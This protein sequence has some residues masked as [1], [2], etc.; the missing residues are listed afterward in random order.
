MHFKTNWTAVIGKKKQ[1]NS[2]PGNFLSMAAFIAQEAVV[3]RDRLKGFFDL[4]S[5][6]CLLL[7]ELPPYIAEKTYH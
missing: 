3:S 6:C 5:L 1:K 2:V 4:S 7:G